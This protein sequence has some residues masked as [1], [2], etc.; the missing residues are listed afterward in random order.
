MSTAAEQ[1]NR[2]VALVADLSRRAAI[3]EEGVS[4]AELAERHGISV[5]QLAAD[6]R[7]L[8]SL[9]EDCDAEW[10]LS[11]SVWQEGDRISLSSGGP[12]QRPIRFTPDELMAVQVGLAAAGGK[13]SWLSAKLATLLARP[14][15]SDDPPPVYV[16]GTGDDATVAALARRAID[17]RRRLEI[18]YA[19][20]GATAPSARLIHPY[21]LVGFEGSTYVVAWCETA[22]DWRRFRIDRVI[23]AT[24]SATT[25]DRRPD[26]EPVAHSRHLFRE[27]GAG[28]DEVRVRF[29]AAVAR[30]VKERHPDAIE[31]GDGSVMVTYPVASA[32][33]LVRHVLQYGPEAEVVE[34]EE[35]REA[36]RRVVA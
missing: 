19:G 29:S 26:F 36:M 35:Y 33:W 1:L 9:G 20:E 4:L 18:A 10:L 24:L 22:R 6:I 28:V 13:A 5:S 12:F 21:Q 30:W 32:D 23:H 7:T 11:L 2:I 15:A 17:S 34:P 27:P 3:G 25:F 16:A 31:S 14:T 8:T